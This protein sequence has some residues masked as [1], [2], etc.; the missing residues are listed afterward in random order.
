MC[1]I[2][3]LAQPQPRLSILQHHHA[4]VTVAGITCTT[5][6]TEKWCRWS[7]AVAC[8]DQVSDSVAELGLRPDPCLLGQGLSSP[9]LSS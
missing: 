8:R 2:W 4:T 6:G 9:Q 1:P 7:R 3:H 5:L